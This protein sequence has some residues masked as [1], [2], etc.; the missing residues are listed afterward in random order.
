MKLRRLSNALGAE[1]CDID[2][3]KPMSESMFG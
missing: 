2:I 3:S 1:I